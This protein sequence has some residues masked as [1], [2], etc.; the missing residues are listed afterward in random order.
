M[1]HPFRHQLTLN[2]TPVED[3]E[4]PLHRR[5]SLYPLLLAI[6][7]LFIHHRHLTHK[8]VADVSFGKDPKKGAPGMTGWQILMLIV[9]RSHG[10]Y[11]FDEME[12]MFNQDR[13]IRQFLELD[14]YDDI[15]H[16][17]TDTLQQNYK[18]VSPETIQS[19]GEV[20]LKRAMIA[21]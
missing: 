17:D 7:Q 13:L 16:F 15:T 11:S 9:L 3:I 21:A 19:I 4:V 20:L 5:N 18:K 6:Q 8:I 2:A 12:V 1:R 14:Y 10:G